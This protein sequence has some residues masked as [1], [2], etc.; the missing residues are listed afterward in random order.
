M[1]LI[2]NTDN[3][4]DVSVNNHLRFLNGCKWDMQKAYEFMQKSVKYRID[5]RLDETEQSMFQNVLDVDYCKN[6][7]KDRVGRPLI[8]M[9]MKNFDPTKLTKDSTMKFMCYFLDYVSYIMASNVD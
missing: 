1:K 2:K 8:W 9:K 5:N 3:M 6:Y 4:K 7:G